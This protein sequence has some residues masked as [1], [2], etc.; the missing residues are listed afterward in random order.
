MDDISRTTAGLTS[1]FEES[2][3]S[4]LLPPSIVYCRRVLNCC[5]RQR[6][7]A[8]CRMGLSSR[9]CSSLPVW[10]RPFPK[11]PGRS[12][13]HRE[14]KSGGTGKNKLNLSWWREGTVKNE[15]R[16]NVFWIRLRGDT[17]FENKILPDFMNNTELTYLKKYWLTANF[18][19]NAPLT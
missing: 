18:L 10:R 13:S 5:V 2:F 7:C 4:P 6:K 14:L 17:P 12:D 19:I 11:T 8:V 1:G 9:L 16:K 15:I 3:F